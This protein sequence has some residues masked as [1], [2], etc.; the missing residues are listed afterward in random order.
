MEIRFDWRLSRVVD[1]EG[2]VLDEMEWGPIRSPSSL[3]TRLG[4]LQSGRMSPEARALRSR[5]PDAEVNHLGAISDSDWPGTS[6]DDEALFSEATAILA[7]RG[8]A[9]SAGDM[10]RR[11]D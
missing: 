3:A 10:D 5:F 1:E 9:E 11:L 4:D 8:V 7:R 2:T 6:P